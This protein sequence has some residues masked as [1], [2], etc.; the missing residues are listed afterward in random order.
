MKSFAEIYEGHANRMLALSKISQ[1]ALEGLRQFSRD[2]SSKFTPLFQSMATYI[3]AHHQNHQEINIPEYRVI[4]FLDGLTLIA[5]VSEMEAYFRDLVVAVLF[6]HP[7]KVGKSSIELKALLDLTSIDEVKKLAAEKFA[8]DM[9]FKKPSDY[10]KD[11]LF[12]LSVSDSI[13]KKS[14]PIFVEAKAR[15]DIGVHNEWIVNDLY[16]T[17]VREV[18]LTPTTDD[19]LSVDHSYIQSVRS[20]C[21][22]LMGDLKA[23]CETTFA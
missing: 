17:K 8:N 7:A 22:E 2:P 14:W 3:P 20:H 6:K 15:R 18:G 10:K 5:T 4:A 1:I 12:V 9:L 16:R 13:F 11:L 21:I 23:H 19:A